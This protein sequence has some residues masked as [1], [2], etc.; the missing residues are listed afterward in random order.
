MN[1]PAVSKIIMACMTD[2]QA[3]YVYLYYG[4]W[5]TLREIS[6]L[7]GTDHSSIMRTIYRALDNIGRYTGYRDVILDNMDAIGNI[8][9]QLYITNGPLDDPPDPPTPERP[10]WGRTKLKMP[11]VRY[12][13]DC[14]IS[15]NCR[16]FPFSAVPASGRVLSSLVQRRKRH[17]DSMAHCWRP[18]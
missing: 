17:M 16:P 6:A 11:R 15:A 5:M 10:D 18:F 13:T 9:Y 4:E 14:R 1:D 7:T 8:A 2:T 3:V 12:D